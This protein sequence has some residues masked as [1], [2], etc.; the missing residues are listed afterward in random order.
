MVHCPL[1][2]KCYSAWSWA[3][4]ARVGGSLGTKLYARPIPVRPFAAEASRTV[5]S[6]HFIGSKCTTEQSR[7]ALSGQQQSLACLASSQ[8]IRAVSKSFRRFADERTI[9]QVTSKDHMDLSSK[10][11]SLVKLF[12]AA[13]S[14]QWQL[15]PGTASLHTSDV[16]Q[17]HQNCCMLDQGWQV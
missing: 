5:G 9:A 6:A 1:Y 11:E 7:D 10:D 3:H 15:L 13:S 2:A 4:Q 17:K 8:G 12:L 16:L 14:H